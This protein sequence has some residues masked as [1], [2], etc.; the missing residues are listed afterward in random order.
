MVSRSVGDAGW[1]ETCGKV[2]N[3]VAERVAGLGVLQQ[4]VAKGVVAGSEALLHRSS[5]VG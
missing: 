2:G 4:L 1:R 5:H 3:K